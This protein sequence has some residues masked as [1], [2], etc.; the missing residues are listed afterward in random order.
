[1]W[2]MGDLKLMA[3]C[4]IL[5]GPSGILI[6]FILGVLAAGIYFMIGIVTK[7]LSADQ[8]SPLGPF[9]VFGVIF[10]ISCRPVIDAVLTWYISLL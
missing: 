5:C 1:M 6:A 10:T 2:V 8:Y 7:Q 3:A 4:G 9:L